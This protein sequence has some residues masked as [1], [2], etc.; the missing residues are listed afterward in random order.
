MFT[1]SYKYISWKKLNQIKLEC[2]FILKRARASTCW[3]QMEDCC[4]EFLQSFWNICYL[5]SH[6]PFCI[7]YH[8]FRL[9]SQKSCWDLWNKE[10]FQITTVSLNKCFVLLHQDL[11]LQPAHTWMI[12]DFMGESHYLVQNSVFSSLYY[13]RHSVHIISSYFREL[14]RELS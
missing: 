9:T 3:W 14:L 8:W 11:A 2:N 12:A 7:G 13:C 4:T 10:F 5:M 1:H 6:T